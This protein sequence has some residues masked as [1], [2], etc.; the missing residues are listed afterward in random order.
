MTAPPPY[1]KQ[2]VSERYGL[3]LEHHQDLL[4]LQNFHIALI[5]DDSGSMNTTGTH[6]SLRSGGL[7]RTTRYGALCEKVEVLV[8]LLSNLELSVDLWFLNRAAPVTNVRSAEQVRTA[9][10]K[11]WPVGS[12]PLTEALDRVLAAAQAD[13]PTLVVIFTDGEPDCRQSFFELLERKQAHISLVACTDQTNQME[14]LDSL[15]G[16]FSHVDVTCDFARETEEL[17]GSYRIA[18]HLVKMLL[19]PIL[20]K[21]CSMDANKAKVDTS[22]CRAKPNISDTKPNFC[23]SWRDPCF[24]VLV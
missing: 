9:F 14:W 3:S 1:E 16:Y 18:D 21:Y 6:Y 5:C 24:C 4:V 20:N 8:E 17:Q 19:G 22:H 13:K 12:T 15:D 23:D 2:Q 10:V 11:S 7:Q